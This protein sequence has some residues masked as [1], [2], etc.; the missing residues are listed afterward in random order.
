M[1][2]TK[3][4]KITKNFNF[5]SVVDK[6][7]LPAYVR[8]YIKKE[9]ILTTYKTS[10]DYGVFTD[11]KIVL[12]DNKGMSKQIFTIPYKSISN[13]SIIFNED[14]AEL[15]LLMDSGYPVILKFINMKGEDKLRLR[16]LYICID[17][18]INNQEPIAEDI[19]NLINNNIKL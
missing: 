18:I 12:F 9:Q 4:K 3:F 14:S 19:K 11:K 7:D 5:S 1:S 16:I 8:Q 13:Q 17:K 10:R 2:Y 6:K 15:D